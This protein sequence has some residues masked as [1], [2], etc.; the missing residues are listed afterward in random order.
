MNEHSLRK[1]RVWRLA[2]KRWQNWKSFQRER[3]R[4]REKEL[5]LLPS[6][7]YFV[8]IGRNIAMISTY[9]AQANSAC[10][11]RESRFHKRI[12]S[13]SQHAIQS[14]A[15][16]KSRR[17]HFDF[18]GIQ[19]WRALKEYFYTQESLITTKKIAIINYVPTVYKLTETHEQTIRAGETRE[20]N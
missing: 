5:L 13:K 2:T 6:Y 10:A 17:Q 18:V 20:I 9:Q 12:S 14:R 8:L 19:Q 3:G 11:K 1:L 4:K 7:F 16:G 15:R